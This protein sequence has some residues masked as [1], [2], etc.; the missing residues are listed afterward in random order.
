[1]KELVI[2]EMTRSDVGFASACVSAEGWLGETPEVFETFLAHDPRGSWVA[3]RGS[4][5]VGICVATRYERSGFIGELI[6]IRE[7]RGKG[8]GSR[9]LG[10]ALRYLG[11]A[12]VES[13]YLDGD[14]DAV[15]L[16]ERAGFRKV[17][18][19]LRFV[20][21]PR[22]KTHPGVRP[23]VH[24]DLSLVL[25]IDRELFGD[26]R[27]FFIENRFSLHP[28][29]CF[30]AESRK[31]IDGFIMARPGAGVLSVG[32]WAARGA[33]EDAVSLLETMA[34]A[35]AGVPLRVGI[36]E[37]NER[38]TRIARSA[39]CFEEREASWR[40]A[41]GKGG[42]LGTHDDLLAIGSAAKG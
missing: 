18:R 4:D 42:L 20:G 22:G 10:R 26:N 1:M 11:A 39:E 21:T 3:Q 35:S 41:L 17:C 7:E 23:A 29:L 38:A 5:P 2:R 16:Y 12:G 30:V 13:V 37:K 25:A 28:G 36:L 27:G 32:P 24:E 33:D 40:M 15:P 9:L 14:R 8:I 6:V 31:G 19:S 34:S